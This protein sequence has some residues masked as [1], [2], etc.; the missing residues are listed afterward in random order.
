MLERPGR[1]AA[2]AG[3]AIVHGEG[4]VTCRTEQVP[5]RDGTR[6]AT[7]VYLPAAPG[8]Y[9]VVMQR[10]PY[11]LK[12]GHG[13]HVKGVAHGIEREPRVQLFVQVPPDT[14][15]EGSSVLVTADT[16]PLPHTE[17]RRFHLR[18]GGRA[19][20]R[21]G[22]G[23]LAA[24]RPSTGPGDTFTYDPNKPAPAL[25]GGLCC[26]SLN[27]R[28]AGP[29]SDLT[30]GAQDQAMLELREDVLVYTSAPLTSALTTIGPVKVRFWAATTARDTDFVA[31]LVDVLP[32]G[33]AYNVLERVIRASL[34][35]GSKSRPSPVQPGAP[36]E[37]DLD[38]GYTATRF[39]AGHR[40]RLDITSSRF[41]H[42]ARNLN[43][44]DHA[45]SQSRIEVA[46]QTILHDREHPSYVELS[47]VPES[48]ATTGRNGR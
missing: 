48:P 35:Q 17:T 44:G 34:R 1:L 38:L 14:G 25:G 20:T 2:Q 22:D 3:S 33:T 29:D 37:Y 26:A 45:A 24:D 23:V 27:A 21:R 12:L 9:P 40:I 6:L 43:T 16:F 39:K 28:V 30:S 7:D 47:V 13:C 11:G 46:T 8:R 32:D 19:N 36:Y 5:M 10:T 15:T 18:S 4:G 31:K 42:L 41:P